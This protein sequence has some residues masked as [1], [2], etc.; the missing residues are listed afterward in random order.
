MAEPEGGGR[1][2]TTTIAFLLMVLI[3][4]VNFVAIR[5]SNRELPPVFGA[6]IRFGAAS[7]LL[8]GYMLARRVPLPQGKSLFGTVVYGLLNFCVSYAFMYYSLTRLPAG[9]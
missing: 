1:D 2:R 7:A 8:T 5:F 4:G 9:V 3:G 6:A